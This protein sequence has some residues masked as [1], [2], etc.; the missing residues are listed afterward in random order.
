MTHL[1]ARAGDTL[2]L[3]TPS[4]A[5]HPWPR[6]ARVLFALAAAAACWSVPVAL[7]YYFLVR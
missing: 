5:I 3:D 6:P 4:S 2:V 1:E 7:L